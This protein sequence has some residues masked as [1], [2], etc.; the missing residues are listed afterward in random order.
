M[1][2]SQ[3]HSNKHRSL[4]VSTKHW[5]SFSNAAVNAS[6]P[7][8]RSHF[9]SYLVHSESSFPLSLSLCGC[10]FCLSASPWVAFQLRVF[11]LELI[12]V[13]LII[14]AV[15][16]NAH[17]TV[18]FVTVVNLTLVAWFWYN[19]VHHVDITVDGNLRLWIGNIEID[20]PFDKIVS[21]R[22]VSMQ[23]PCSVVSCR[24]HRGLMSN[25]TDG[26]CI[27]TTVPSTPFWLWPRSAGK[28][29][30]TCCFGLLGC[31]RLTVV[32]SP[33][34]GGLHF[35]REVESEMRNVSSGGGR[36]GRTQPPSVDP[37]TLTQ[38]QD[39]LDV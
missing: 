31:P 1:A 34:G 17:A 19:V 29:D 28:P 23:T 13:F 32:F 37:S 6:Y 4:S 12:F 14:A 20:V 39:F 2:A 11:M 16:I 24:P 35:I 7:I 8:V 5:L 18:V 36:T 10:F 3:C 38:R 15:S 21:M 25:P 22:R 9:Y 27:V 26:V 33:A 30:R